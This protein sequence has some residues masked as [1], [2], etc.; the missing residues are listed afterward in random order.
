MAKQARAASWPVK[1]LV[2]ATPISGPAN[3]GSTKSASRAMLL[4]GTLTTDSRCLALLAQSRSAASVS[5]VSPD[6]LTNR[7]ARL[8]RK[9]GSR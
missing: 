3:V 9:T 6:W 1:A 5:A 8:G 4:S 7:P 2:V